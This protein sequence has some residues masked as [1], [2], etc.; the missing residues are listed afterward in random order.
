MAA[1]AFVRDTDL[2]KAGVGNEAA[3]VGVM[4]GHAFGECTY[5]GAIEEAEVA[6][7]GWKVEF[8]DSIEE[9]VK[10]AAL[11][12]HELRFLAGNTDAVDDLV[13]L[14]PEA[15]KVGDYLGRVLAIG[16]EL[17]DGVAAGVEVTSED[18]SL[19]PEV[20]AQADAANAR[21]GFLKATDASEG[22]IGATVVGEDNFKVVL[23][24]PATMSIAE[25]F[26]NEVD[27][28]VFVVDRDND[29]E[30]FHAHARR[31]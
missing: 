14:F 9:R 19:V 23:R 25:S 11:P 4:L 27:V 18:V 12:L 7:A 2:P 26:V 30:E 15:E 29:T 22:V 31:N 13:A 6:S 1:V 16:I 3:Q 8:G 28:F 21:I 20:A 5:N 24:K 10:D 17:D